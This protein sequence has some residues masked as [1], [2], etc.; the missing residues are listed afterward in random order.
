M[1]VVLEII[2]GVVYVDMFLI[3]HVAGQ[4]FG[5]GSSCLP[6][7]VQSLMRGRLLQLLS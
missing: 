2:A 6:G 4:L 1:I 7:F 5:A 3:Q